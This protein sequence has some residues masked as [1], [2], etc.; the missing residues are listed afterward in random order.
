[1]RASDSASSLL[2]APF[3][4]CETADIAAELWTGCK[5]PMGCTAAKVRGCGCGRT[6]WTVGADASKCSWMGPTTEV[7]GSCAGLQAPSEWP[8]SLCGL[9]PAGAGNDAAR[10]VPKGVGG[11]DIRCSSPVV[12][13]ARLNV[14]CN[15]AAPVSKPSSM[16]LM[17]VRSRSSVA[18]ALTADADAPTDSP[19]SMRPMRSRSVCSS[20]LEKFLSCAWRSRRS[21]ANIS[22]IPSRRASN[23]ARAARSSVIS[24]SIRDIQ[25][26][27]PSSPPAPPSVSSRNLRCSIATSSSSQAMRRSKPACCLE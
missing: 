17:R 2:A 18:S 13:P 8:P 14:S 26:R 1:M 22:S 24:A 20:S 25:A 16:R 7:C 11:C 3:T 6:M 15:A 27:K 10:P 21:M 23:L 9:F 4:E 5:Y 19:S 12:A